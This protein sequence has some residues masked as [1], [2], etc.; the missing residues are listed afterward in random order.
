MAELDAVFLDRDGVLN[1]YL[2]AAYVVR[3]SQLEMISGVAFAIKRLNEAGVPAIVISNQQGVGKG[4][5]TDA[6][7]SDVETAIRTD[8]RLVAGA[9]LARFYYCTHRSEDRCLCRK[10]APGLILNA[11]RDF[12]L[13]PSR[14]AFIGDSSADM[15]AAAAAA[16]RW[17]LLVLS[18]ATKHYVPGNA[19]PGFRDRRLA[20]PP[21]LPN[22]GSCREGIPVENTIEPDA[23]FGS[24]AT[25]ID[26][27]LEAKDD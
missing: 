15:E 6:D 7:L 2:P 27:L 10:P 12:S 24:A 5:M 25:A 8:L 22:K 23:V 18:G 16:L 20:T 11:M 26:W 21:P 1:R 9:S 3:P 13:N 4:L 17:K 19:H 14:C